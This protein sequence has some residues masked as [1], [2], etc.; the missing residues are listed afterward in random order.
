MTFESLLFSGNGWQRPLDIATTPR[1]HNPDNKQ[2]CRCIAC[3]YTLYPER[4]HSSCSLLLEI[5]L[6]HFHDDKQRQKGK[7]GPTIYRAPSC[8]P[9]PSGVLSLTSSKDGGAPGSVNT[10]SVDAGRDRLRSSLRCVQEP[11][12]LPGQQG[13]RRPR[14]PPH[15]PAL[16]VGF[17]QYWGR[18]S[19]V[20]ISAG[21]GVTGSAPARLCTIATGPLRPAGA[22]AGPWL[23]PNLQHPAGAVGAIM[24]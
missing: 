17:A 6:R 21:L 10:G 8:L 3:Q 11:L 15:L 23:P 9:H 2:Q 13:E 12:R 19:E 1:D 7:P 24:L 5:P 18:Q 16:W 4:A 20:Q 14:F 22:R